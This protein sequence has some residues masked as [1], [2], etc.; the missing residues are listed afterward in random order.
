MES[1]L[2]LSYTLSR[3]AKRRGDPE[4]LDLPVP[5]TKA[6][7][8]YHGFFADAPR[9][10]GLCKGLLRG[11]GVFS[12]PPLEERTEV[13][14]RFKPFPYYEKLSKTMRR[15]TTQ[16]TVYLLRLLLVLLTA[17]TL[18]ACF[19]KPAPVESYYNRGVELYDQGKY[20]EAIDAYKLALRKNPEDLFAKYNL[21]VVYQ[22][23]GKHDRALDLYQEILKTTEDTNSRINIAAIYYNRGDQERA[24]Q[25]LE[26][27]AKNNRD[28]A[29]PSSALG[30]YLVRQNLLGPAEK[31]YLEALS[32]DD[33]HALTYYRLGRLY[34]QQ[35]KTDLCLENLKKAV[36]LAPETPDYLEAL[37]IQHE[38]QNHALAAIN[39]LERVSV[40]QPER[41]EIFIWLGNLY[42]SE[43]L[44]K[45]AIQ[46]YWSAVAIR[47]TDPNVHRNLAE[48]Y[49]LL[50][51]IELQELENQEDQSSLAQSP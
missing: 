11:E 42:K 50:S 20:A 19:N 30:E 15:Q 51:E 22:D 4:V 43:R 46:N 8:K 47:D 34:C 38:K 18:T 23:Q 1:T 29:E 21:A 44:Y 37:A 7:E 6:N 26:T 13:R 27:A 33:Q 49:S 12:S 41:V 28:S 14:R 16:T 2:S 40:L 35:E 39:L 32:I 3:A 9:K 31:K 10:D 24:L 5:G 25:E 45:K 17:G 36:E 48:I